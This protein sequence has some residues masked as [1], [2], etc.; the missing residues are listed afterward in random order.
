MSTVELEHVTVELDGRTVLEDVCLSA[1][2]GEFVGVVGG[3]G[4][5]KT[6]LL[7]SIGGLV[8]VTAGSIRIGGVDVTGRTPADRDVAM[9]FQVP[10]LLPQRDVRGNVSFPL[11]LR[12][13][14]ADEITRR[15]LAE[16]RAL[17]I[18]GL[19]ARTPRELSAG[20]AQLV[21]VARALVRMP[22]LLLLD[23]PLARLDAAFSQHM[24]G[25]L[26]LLQQGYGVTTFMATN[27][28]VEAM[29]LPDRL[30]V[31]DRG[32][33]VQVAPPLEVYGHPVNLTAASCTGGLSTLD[34]HVEA[35][36]DG[37][38][39]VHP[40]FRHRSWRPSLAGYVGAFVVAGLRPTWVRID[41][42]GPIEARITQVGLGSGT[43]TVALGQG[44]HA[45]EIEVA[46][47]D[48]ALRRDE[49][50]RVRIDEVELFDPVTSDRI[51]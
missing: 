26:R 6:T 16:T 50:L 12:R 13:E 32:R 39:L 19:L 40:S 4:A 49:L 29:A 2:D 23:E 47:S 11:E 3:S 30:V 36:A 10:A 31:L 14:G 7:R 46:S 28:P 43:I 35:D 17:H 45:D 8:P 20:E 41:D 5:G 9:V 15:V 25:E 22:A 18:E 33:V 37:Y 27:D 24:R 1:A 48:P 51:A 34:V 21:Q 38:W 44:P 42:A